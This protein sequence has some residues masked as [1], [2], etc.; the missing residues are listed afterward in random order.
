M[1]RAALGPEFARMNP[2]EF[3]QRAGPAMEAKLLPWT[4]FTTVI[5]ILG[6]GLIYSGAAYAYRAEKATSNA[7]DESRAIKCVAI[8][9]STLMVVPGRLIRGRSRADEHRAVLAEI[10][11]IAS[12]EAVDA[13]LV[14]G[15]LFDTATPSPESEAIVYEALLALAATGAA[16]VV[17]AGNHDSDRRLQAERAGTAGAHHHPDRRGGAA[18][19]SAEHACQRRVGRGARALARGRGHE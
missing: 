4:I 3:M 19:Q 11:A 8:M 16:V 1:L 5:F 17:L 7:R 13:V 10:A 9:H 14:V 2:T 6:S 12:A 15:D 18:R